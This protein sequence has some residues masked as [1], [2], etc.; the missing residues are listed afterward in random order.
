[1]TTVSLVLGSGGA[2]GYA[3]IGVI[4]ELERRGYS[5][6]SIAGSSMGALVG[7]LYAADCLQPFRAWAVAQ[8]S[9]D[10]LRMLDLS[11]DAVGLIRGDKVFSMLS[12]I[13]GKRLIEE[14]PLPYTAVATDLV[15]LK[16]IWFQEGD[17]LEAIRASISIP[18]LFTPVV[19]NG[20]VLVDGGLL[21]PIPIAPTVSAHA[22]LIIAVNLNAPD[23]AAWRISSPQVER[24]RAAQAPSA[25]SGDSEAP[26]LLD[27][28]SLSSLGASLKRKL[29]RNSAEQEGVRRKQSRLGR[30]EVIYQSVEA[31]QA[32]LTQY[33]IAGYPPDV[34]VKVPKDSC[35]FYEFYRAEEL[36]AVGR[37]ATALALDQ[38]ERQGAP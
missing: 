18:S 38:F 36:I 17:L 19:R 16:E 27:N 6:V 34:L 33:K 7:G 23:V 31:M 12:R 30:L 28:W 2:R 21:N 8:R 22:D 20:R 37:R 14:L 24:E 11:F 1:M 13:V 15:G 5:I 4:D 9:V 26:Q 29:D 32:T 10:V 35:R 25:S 3:H